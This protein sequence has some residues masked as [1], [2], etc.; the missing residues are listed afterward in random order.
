MID[1]SFCDPLPDLS[2]C[3][4]L[5]AAHDNV[6]VLRSF[7]KFYGLAGARLGFAIG[8]QAL[9]DKRADRMGSWAVSGPALAIGKAALEDE[10]WAIR[11]TEQLADHANHPFGGTS[12]Q[13]FG[14]RE[15][16]Q[17]VISAKQI[18]RSVHQNE[19]ICHQV[20]APTR[21]A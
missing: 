5:T 13:A 12:V 3:P 19:P 10:I 1:E 18:R 15:C 20:S 2:V 16:G 21:T 9:L 6:L 7:G 8:E 17:G 14:V 4:H 11:M